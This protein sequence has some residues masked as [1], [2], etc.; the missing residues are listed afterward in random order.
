MPN[1]SLGELAAGI[2]RPIERPIKRGRR[3]AALPA[4]A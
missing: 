4:I 1:G 2:K 3:I